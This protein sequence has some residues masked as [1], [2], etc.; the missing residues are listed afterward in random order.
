[1]DEQIIRTS[2]G[3][4]YVSGITI[5]GAPYGVVLSIAAA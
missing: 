1:M 4:V 3:S 2:C 5:A